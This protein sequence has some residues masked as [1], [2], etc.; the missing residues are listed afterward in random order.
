MDIQAEKIEL[1]KRLLDTEDQSI[2][3]EVKHVFESH[4]QDFWIDL[5]E[6]VKRGIERSK[7]QAEA[8]LLTSHDEVMKKYAKYL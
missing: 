6:H 2:L 8:G 7:K 5:P 4:E 1:V 3:A